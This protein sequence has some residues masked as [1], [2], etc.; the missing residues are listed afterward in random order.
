MRNVTSQK[1]WNSADLAIHLTISSTSQVY[2]ARPMVTQMQTSAKQ[3]AI[4]KVEYS[5]Y[6]EDNKVRVANRLSLRT[7]PLKKKIKSCLMLR[8]GRHHFNPIISVIQ[9]NVNSGVERQFI[10]WSRIMVDKEVT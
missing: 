5:I 2:R 6:S 3:V 7:I 4:P 9:Y 10:R 8:G 1:T